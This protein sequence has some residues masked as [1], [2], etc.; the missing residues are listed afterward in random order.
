MDFQEV[1]SLSITLG[2]KLVTIPLSS[3]SWARPAPNLLCEKETTTSRVC[4]LPVGDITFPGFQR[5]RSKSGRS[6]T[7]AVSVDNSEDPP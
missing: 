5:A 7:A 4:K 1:R 2:H 3:S 6:L